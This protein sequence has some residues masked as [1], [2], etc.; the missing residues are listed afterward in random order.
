MLWNILNGPRER[1][2]IFR[3]GATSRAGSAAMPYPRRV[4]ITSPQRSRLLSATGRRLTKHLHA[5]TLQLRVCSPG[6]FLQFRRSGFGPRRFDG[7]A[8]RWALFMLLGEMSLISLRRMSRSPESSMPGARILTGS[9]LRREPRSRM[10]LFRWRASAGPGLAVMIDTRYGPD[11]AGGL[12]G[13]SVL[14]PCWTR[15][16]IKRVA[17]PP[18]THWNREAR[19]CALWSVVPGQETR[20]RGSIR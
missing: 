3:A 19:R 1:P 7:P 14:G 9:L 4:R 10:L 6:Y 12:L 5:R 18:G 13:I 20:L 8:P 17:K 11:Q 2:A 15:D 16:S